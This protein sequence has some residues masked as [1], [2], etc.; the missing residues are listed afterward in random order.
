MKTELAVVNELQAG[1]CEVAETSPVSRVQSPMF[2]TA[3]A[4]RVFEGLRF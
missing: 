4:S 3:T 1:C 2:A